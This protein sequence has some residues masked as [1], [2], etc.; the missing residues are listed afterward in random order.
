MHP[1]QCA[2]GVHLLRA[3]HHMKSYAYTRFRLANTWLR[4]Q[5]REALVVATGVVLGLLLLAIVGGNQCTG[6]IIDVL[7]AVPVLVRC[8]RSVQFPRRATMTS[9]EHGLQSVHF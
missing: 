8:P 4:L 7:G 6:H 5:V 3:M 1:T 2:Y 9:S